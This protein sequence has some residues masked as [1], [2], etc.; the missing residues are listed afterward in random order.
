MQPKTIKKHLKQLRA[1]CIEQ[2]DDLVLKRVAYEMECAIRRVTER[3]VGW[4]SLSDLARGAAHLIRTEM[5][6]EQK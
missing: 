1:E 6:L 3:T 5:K 2:T 4:P